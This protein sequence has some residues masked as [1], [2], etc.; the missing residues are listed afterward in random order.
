MKSLWRELR[1]KWLAVGIING[2]NV[3]SKQV[4]AVRSAANSRY[5]LEGM[6][7]FLQILRGC[8]RETRTEAS[9]TKHSTGTASLTSVL[10]ISTR[11][12]QK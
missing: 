11:F 9:N 12:H 10:V 2:N 5:T 1:A 7:I 3:D 8:L 6:T 4:E